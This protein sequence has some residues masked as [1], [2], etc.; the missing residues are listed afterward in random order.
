MMTAIVKLQSVVVSVSDNQVPT[1]FVIL[2]PLPESDE[3]AERHEAIK[4][5]SCFETMSE[6]MGSLTEAAALIQE[7]G[8]KGII[9]KAVQAATANAR[10]LEMHLV[11]ERCY[12]PQPGRNKSSG[13]WPINITEPSETIPKILP[14]ARGCLKA[15]KVA[16]GVLKMGRLFGLPTPVMPAD[17]IGLADEAVGNI[18]DKAGGSLK[19]YACMSA[20]FEA[21]EGEEAQS[22]YCLREF[23]RFL[24][25]NDEKDHWCDLSCVLLPGAEKT[26][27]VCNTCK[28]VLEKGNKPPKPPP[29][30][31]PPKVVKLV[32]PNPIAAAKPKVVA[33]SA[34]GG[35]AP[36]AGN[37]AGSASGGPLAGK[38]K[39]KQPSFME[40]QAEELEHRKQQQKKEQAA[41]A[42]AT[43]K[44]KKTAP[45]K[46]KQMQ[47]QPT[48]KQ[49][50]K[51]KQKSQSQAA[52]GGAAG[53]NHSSAG[54]HNSSNYG[55]NGPR[56]HPPASRQNR[57]G[58]G[59]R[60]FTPKEIDGVAKQV[61]QDL[62]AKTD[63]HVSASKVTAVVA[64]Q[65]SLVR[66]Q[67]FGYWQLDGSL[68]NIAKLTRLEGEVATYIS[69]YLTMATVATLHDLE[70]HLAELFK[71]PTYAHLCLGPLLKHP[72][73]V[74]RFS[75]APG[76]SAIPAITHVDV[77]QALADYRRA[78]KT[79]H[80]IKL[81][82]FLNWFAQKRQVPSPYDLCIRLQKFFVGLTCKR[83]GDVRRK[84]NDEIIPA[85]EK[86]CEKI[87][88][89]K[90][91]LRQAELDLKPSDDIIKL[92]P[93][94]TR[95]I[96]T[97]RPKACL[98][99]HDELLSKLFSSVQ[100][101]LQ[102][103][104]NGK[105]KKKKAAAPQYTE[106]LHQILEA[107][108]ILIESAG[109]INPAAVREAFARVSG[110]SDEDLAHEIL[111]AATEVGSEILA[112]EQRATAGA[113]EMAGDSGDD[114][115]SGDE[116]SEQKGESKAD[117]AASNKGASSGGRLLAAEEV[118][119]S[120]AVLRAYGLKTVRVED[121]G[122]EQHDDEDFGA[123]SE[124]MGMLDRSL[125]RLAYDLYSKE[126]HFLLELVQNADDNTYEVSKPT[127]RF[128]VGL[129][130][131]VVCNNETGFESRHVEAL[132]DVAKSSKG[133][134]GSGY[135]GQKGIGFKS[136]FTVSHRPEIHSNGF[137]FA[138]DAKHMADFV[139]ASSR[140]AVAQDSEWNQWL[141]EE[142]P[143]LFVEAVDLVRRF[144]D[145][146]GEAEAVEHAKS[147]EGNAAAR[148]ERDSGFEP[149]RTQILAAVPA[150]HDVRGFFRPL[151][152]DIVRRLGQVSCIPTVD[153]GWCTPCEALIAD[154]ATRE[155]VPP[156]MLLAL[157]GKRYV[158]PDLALLTEEL[159]EDTEDDPA[160]SAII[161]K[162]LRAAGVKTVTANTIAS[163]HCVPRLV[164]RMLPP[165]SA[166]QVSSY[167]NFIR[168]FIDS[169]AS[170][171][172]TS[173]TASKCYAQKLEQLCASKSP[174]EGYD[175]AVQ[176]LRLLTSA[177]TG[178]QPMSEDDRSI[179][180][181]PLPL[182]WLEE[183]LPFIFGNKAVLPAAVED[184]TG[185]RSTLWVSARDMPFIND[186]FRSESSGGDIAA[187]FASDI[188]VLEFTPAHLAAV[189]PL[190]DALK[191]QRLSTA[192]EK[193]FVPYGAD[194]L[195][196]ADIY[197]VV[198]AAV[199]T[200]QRWLYR[201]RRQIYED[202]AASGL[203][204]RLKKLRC[205][206]SDNIEV[207]HRVRVADSWV[208]REKAF[209]AWLDRRDESS[210]I[211]YVSRAKRD[212]RRA[213]LQAVSG[214]FMPDGGHDQE[215]A[216]LLLMVDLLSRGSAGLREEELR[217]RDVPLLE[218]GLEP[219]DIAPAGNIV[220][221]SAVF[222]GSALEDTEEG[223]APVDDEGTTET[224]MPSIDQWP[225]PRGQ[226]SGLDEEQKSLAGPS[227]GPMEA[228]TRATG[229]AGEV[230]PDEVL[231]ESA[232]EGVEGRSGPSYRSSN[233]AGGDLGVTSADVDPGG[234]AG[235][236]A[237]SAFGGGS[238]GSGGASGGGASGGG[239]GTGVGV[240]GTFQPLP[241]AKLDEYVTA[242]FDDMEH[243]V[244][245]EATQSATKA[246][247]A[248]ANLDHQNSSAT[249]E[250]RQT[251]LIGEALVFH[252]LS[253]LARGPEGG[254][255]PFDDDSESEDAAA[256][257]AAG[258]HG[259]A[260][261]TITWMNEGGETG[262]PY[263]IMCT[264]ASASDLVPVNDLTDD[265]S[266]VKDMCTIADWD[267]AA[268][269]QHLSGIKDAAAWDLVSKLLHPSKEKREEVD[270]K[271]LV[272][273]HP[274]FN[275]EDAAADERL[276]AIIKN[277]EVALEKLATIERTT[278]DI[279]AFEHES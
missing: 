174:S 233:V 80:N 242:A 31:P 6:M 256:A 153:G 261:W 155:V 226:Q 179:Q 260:R 171:G 177:V 60:R 47:P 271:A 137:H 138:L 127:L 168:V 229:E 89:Q 183:C 35:G 191:L 144:A 200:A 77:V 152:A 219:W 22:G 102:P 178:T 120:D 64:R 237:G 108:T 209:D 266:T 196:I 24:K 204:E 175:Q 232:G 201:H 170:G 41:L 198:A 56:H 110:L 78:T 112:Q 9:D 43:E 121:A 273:K 132:C 239:G 259:G 82:Q 20:A 176:I 275:P 180:T 272:N 241:P 234:I 21:G 243:H 109:A 107:A 139:L 104:G 103:M 49:R 14:M 225:P 141:R 238:G 269:T 202:L 40:I 19:D 75:P 230:D 76:L 38:K 123:S 25:A 228:K 142:M 268:A 4:M 254:R 94:V 28:E 207:V 265:H 162:M 216:D 147:E 249:P 250:Q 99:S 181:P 66:W 52:G 156:T 187:M 274:F 190:L 54:R 210:M 236:A 206:V 222:A 83:L 3:T 128:D 32:T 231:Q 100:A 189:S 53:G 224:E 39:K 44:A 163:G 42:A 188:K 160:Q 27:W 169:P 173:D 245:T 91:A 131:I 218:D 251:A 154:E 165:A 11:C 118:K 244:L 255:L 133:A 1:A 126:T 106:L 167:L 161:A 88:R 62:A 182:G 279:Q 73:V 130:A 58:G 186:T 10:Q 16:N 197:P 240:D 149:D 194:F 278:L 166:E 95:L 85:L 159:F 184:E 143:S 150:D 247:L 13:V 81:E 105:K 63:D 203:G 253:N 221:A 59:S 2:P 136:V 262:A 199:L 252:Y 92:T 151:A 263:D 33:S 17:L 111:E 214:L 145:N 117:A 129:E 276:D 211:L 69:C 74:D 12:E 116:G 29:K 125:E 70:R 26:C 267:D 97:W 158:A 148:D 193:E 15:A 246:W 50:Q 23:K 36:P 157:L 248:T 213:I 86:E 87:L 79:F 18:K 212:E 8:A 84:E 192:V 61:W 270:L 93:K 55:G 172:P 46:S 140:E 208:V 96:L 34:A 134:G 220:E 215:L 71:V 101:G 223:K 114:G 257:A 67:D 195:A 185:K 135:I 68:P 51:Q 48:H 65:F 57:G 235:G 115:D 164:D 98:L 205:C 119:N 5:S 45:K 124:L 7:K 227:S 217:R 146:H 122:K 264:R 113:G 277:Q 258:T 72:V 30:P 37:A 90:L